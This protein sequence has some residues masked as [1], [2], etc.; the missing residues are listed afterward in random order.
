MAD[1]PGALHDLVVIGASAGGVETLT[2]IVP[3]L[4][5]DLPA[6]ICV[7]LH[8]APR[9]PSALAHIL[10]RAAPMPCRAAV[11]GEPLRPSEILVAPPDRHLEI[12]DGVVRLTMGPAENGHRPAVDVL[13]RS[14]AAAKDSHVVGVV[15]SGTRDD[16]TAGLAVIKASGGLAIV[17][18][19]EDALYP[20]MP[21]SA[22]ANVVVDAIVPTKLVAGT[23]AA[24]VRGERAAGRRR[25]EPAA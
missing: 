12:Q 9:S 21:A 10:S 1:E 23:I 3:A 11:D 5:P 16:G 7:V 15:L 14:A 18:D 6:T 4:P 13:F 22:L 20:G 2:R 19:P 17:Q 8:L 24:M 25:L